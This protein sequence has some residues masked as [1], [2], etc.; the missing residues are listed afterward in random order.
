M[1]ALKIHVVFL[2][3]LFCVPV[4]S[5]CKATARIIN[6]YSIEATLQEGDFFKLDSYKAGFSIKLEK[7]LARGIWAT[8]QNKNSPQKSCLFQ[9]LPKGKYRVTFVPLQLPP[10]AKAVIGR[11]N[12]RDELRKH[13]NLFLSNTVS[14]GDK[15]GCPELQSNRKNT[16]QQSLTVFPNPSTGLV[17]IHNNSRHSM[18]GKVYDIT[19]QLIQTFHVPQ[20]HSQEVIALQKPGLYLFQW[21]DANGTAQ[22]IKV[23]IIK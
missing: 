6:C 16:D 5:F 9:H 10:S 8:I 21:T 13:A 14:I 12:R 4:H 11:Q 22:L 2:L 17:N 15:K 20:P 23:T 7:E 3:F 1:K 19:G 18:R